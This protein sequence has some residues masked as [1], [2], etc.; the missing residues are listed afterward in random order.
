MRAGKTSG[1]L[2]DMKLTGQ[3]RDMKFTGQ[4]RDMKLTG[5][6]SFPRYFL[7]QPPTWPLCS[8]YKYL[9]SFS[10]P[11][12]FPSLSF[13]QHKSP[14]RVSRQVPTL[15]STSTISH[16]LQHL[17]ISTRLDFNSATQQ[18]SNSSTQQLSNSP[19]TTCRS[20][21]TRHLDHIVSC[22]YIMDA[23]FHDPISWT[24]VS[25]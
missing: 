16:L 3:L 13:F 4:L 20:L 8:V 9:P 2:R 10:F 15:P 7:R 21:L 11:S 24:R 5:L 14:L 12:T 23:F 1:Q 25:I 6:D 18:L 22:L 19:P 17:T